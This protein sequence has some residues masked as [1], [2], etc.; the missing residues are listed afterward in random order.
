MIDS[1]RIFSP[2]MNQR[3]IGALA[4]LGATSCLSPITHV[5]AQSD[6]VASNPDLATVP[7]REVMIQSGSS[8]DITVAFLHG[9][10]LGKSGNTVIQS[11]LL[12]NS[13]ETFYQAC[14]SQPDANA[15]TVLEESLTKAFITGTV[16]YRE[17]IALPGDVTVR[18]TLQ[19]VSQINAANAILAEVLFQ[20][21]K[22]SVPLP[23]SLTYD[24]SKIE[25]GRPGYVVV[26]EVFDPSGKT[27][28]VTGEPYEV[29]SA[30]DADYQPE[31]NLLLKQV[32]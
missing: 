23:F 26:S 29:F 17:R 7:C 21:G 20:P 18:V 5:M 27:L 22:R 8:R 12:T 10:I 11:E 32:R 1:N 28:W 30:D 31:V 16:T 14:L 3:W 2:I 6:N 15:I 4:L 24:P 19:D 13:T 9:F 25:L